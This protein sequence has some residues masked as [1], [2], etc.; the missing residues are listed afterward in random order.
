M[1]YY[2]DVAL[3]VNEKVDVSP[4]TQRIMR[5]LSFDLAGRSE[6]CRL[7]IA[8]TLKW[9]DSYPDIDH[10]V[11]WLRSLND[12]DYRFLRI[13]EDIGDTEDLG[14][15]YD[16]PFEIGIERQFCYDALDDTL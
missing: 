15:F 2:S 9:Y 13:G 12:E 4:E 10:L 7:W 8:T 6:G 16:N 3:V 1:G 5:L 14:S 11:Q